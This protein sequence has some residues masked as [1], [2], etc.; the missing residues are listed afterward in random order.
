[1]DKLKI[2][3]LTNCNAYV[4][5]ANWLGRLSEFTSP[6]V[7]ARVGEH[8]GLG[9][10]GTLEVPGGGLEAMEFGLKFASFYPECWREVYHPRIALRVQVRASIEQYTAGGL[11]AETGLQVNVTGFYKSGNMGSFKQHEQVQ[12]EGKFTCH[13]F[14]VVAGGVEVVEV[15][16]VN[17]IH[18][19]AGVDVLSQFRNLIGG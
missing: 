15:D 19:V 14:Q 18:R 10:V 6:E 17:N 3:S 16:V 13:Y 7:K 8:R 9:M 5:G 2:N 4:N 11:T 1:V 12:P